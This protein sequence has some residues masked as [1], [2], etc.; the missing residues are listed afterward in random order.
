MKRTIS[1]LL[2]IILLLGI[3]PVSALAATPVTSV[4]I[5]IPDRLLPISGNK[6]E[7]QF[8]VNSSSPTD[9]NY[10]R[11]ANSSTAVVWTASWMYYDGYSWE[12]LN[13]SDP[14]E[15]FDYY[16]STK[17]KLHLM[18]QTKSGYTFPSSTSGLTVNCAPA[19]SIDVTKVAGDL[20]YV[21]LY[22]EIIHPYGEPG[23]NAY[24]WIWMKSF[25][26][27]AMEYTT[28][29]DFLD[30]IELSDLNDDLEIGVFRMYYTKPDGTEGQ[31]ANSHLFNAANKYELVLRI[32]VKDSREA[33]FMEN[34]LLDYV[35]GSVNSS[36]FTATY[37]WFYIPIE[38]EKLNLGEY[39]VDLTKGWVDPYEK[40][41]TEVQTEACTNILYEALNSFDEIGDNYYDVDGDGVWDFQRVYRTSPTGWKLNPDTKFGGELVYEL[42][43]DQKE[44]FGAK[45]EHFYEKLTIK[46]PGQDLGTY[47]IDLSYDGYY[48]FEWVVDDGAGPELFFLILGDYLTSVG[49]NLIDLNHDGIADMKLD[50]NNSEF[51]LVETCRL[52]GDYVVPFRDDAIEYFKELAHNYYS[53]FT[54]RFPPKGGDLGTFVIDL[55]K[56][57]PIWDDN[58][59][60]WNELS[61]L[62]QHEYI[63]AI[64]EGDYFS[65]DL[66]GD[67]TGD[68]TDY[69][70]GDGNW[71]LRKMENS[72]LTGGYVYNVPTIEI[73]SARIGGF[74]YY[75]SFTFIF[76]KLPFV[77]VKTSAYYYKAVAWAFF[78]DP[79]I[80]AGTDSTHFSPNNTCTRGQIVTFLWR[81]A[82]C[83]T[84]TITENP[85]TDVKSTDYWYSAVL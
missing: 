80:T 76:D 45:E 58:E 77:D 7:T 19:W 21:D 8:I 66:D 63:T 30:E 33:R 62:I 13:A 38:V 26:E 29:G 85:F 68:I 47:I 57:D 9:S 11:T 64:D 72:N 75:S 6:V 31:V 39:T 55:S 60:G 37:A 61:Y 22:M 2:C 24:D 83:P 69:D 18:L 50:T 71:Y 79:Q 84:P 25:P 65:F 54:F 46:F 73:L 40:A 14:T 10:I 74:E 81:A 5:L 15:Y 82:G 56:G 28:V 59:L 41:T 49:D 27:K 3:L 23:S 70:G 36:S 16:G 78:H 51:T 34:T 32:D 44:A 1:I 42:T 12:Y 52:Y 20:A 4:S 35:Y 67:G 48:S 53:S 43:E 17:W